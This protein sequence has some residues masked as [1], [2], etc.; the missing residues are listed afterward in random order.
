V[1][2]AGPSSPAGSRSQSRGRGRVV[3]TGSLRPRRT[4]PA[5][6]AE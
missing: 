1:P 2:L 6:T 5:A 4:A 3:E